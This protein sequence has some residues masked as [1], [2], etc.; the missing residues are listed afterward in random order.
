MPSAGFF[1]KNIWGATL[2]YSKSTESPDDD[3]MFVGSDVLTP[4]SPGGDPCDT[5]A[6]YG[7]VLDCWQRSE[8]R[9]ATAV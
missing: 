5:S 1:G 6:E 8:S 3:T 4:S 9:L 2:Q 7:Y